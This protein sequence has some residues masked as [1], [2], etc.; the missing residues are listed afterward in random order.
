MSSEHIG[1]LKQ[2]GLATQAVAGTPDDPEIWIPCQSIDFKPIF[3][4]DRDDSAMGVIEEF[5]GEEHIQ[6]KSGELAVEC[7]GRDTSIG[8]FLKGVFGTETLV[9]II[10][11]SG[12][13]GG[14]PARG[15]VITS[16]TGSWAGVIRKIFIVGAVTYYAVSTTTGTIGDLDDKT[17][18]TNGTWTG[19]TVEQGDF[20]DAKGHLFTRL[21]QNYGHPI[22]S[23]YTEDVVAGREMSDASIDTFDFELMP[24][25]APKINCTFKGISVVDGG[26]LTP[27]NTTENKFLGKHCS[28]KFAANEAALNAASAVDLRRFKLSIAKNL[29]E[30]MKLGQDGAISGYYPQQFGITGDLE[31]LFNS[32]TF[33][34]YHLNNSY[35]ACRIAIINSSVAAIEDVTADIF[36]S[37]YI[38]IMQAYFQEW[39]QSNDLN[40]L[41]SQT[42]GYTG[43]YEKT[44]TAASIECLL[45]NTKATVY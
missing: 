45:I 37:L 33:R 40:G 26:T 31:A 20:A 18:L 44:T 4:K 15:D 34:N 22:Y 36:P 28:V 1:R 8:Y 25:L 3:E 27:A 41:T 16:A 17:D 43:H 42:L 14:T 13:S 21:N 24:E 10:T 19:G 9:S 35:M 32:E 5:S 12:A 2:F 30:E 38:D 7:W 11:I 29:Q 39:S 6:K 23:L